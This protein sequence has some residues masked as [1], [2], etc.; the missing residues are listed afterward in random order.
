VANLNKGAIWNGLDGNVTAVGSAGPLSANFYGAFDQG[1][2]VWEWNEQLFTGYGDRG[3]R[4]G[5]WVDASYA[6]LAPF[7]NY[8]A[9]SDGNIAGYE[10]SDTG[11]RLA[12]I[13]E[14][15]SLALL[16]LGMPLLVGRNVRRIG[17]GGTRGAH[18]P[19]TV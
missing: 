9:G 1:G 2:N 7:R 12:G 17:N 3:L 15:A 4:G 8:S 6:L 11:F 18:G 14:P 19:M 13:P 10:H 16:A 5:S